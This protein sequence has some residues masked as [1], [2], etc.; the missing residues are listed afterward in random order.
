MKKVNV[1]GLFNKGAKTL[2]RTA[3]KLIS[4]GSGPYETSFPGGGNSTGTCGKPCPR[5]STTA[6]DAQSE[7]SFCAPTINGYGFCTTP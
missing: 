7:C 5:Y 1:N 2:D 3:L 6:C 4:G